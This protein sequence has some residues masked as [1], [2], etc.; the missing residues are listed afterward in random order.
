MS[1]KI[2]RFANVAFRKRTKSALLRLYKQVHTYFKSNLRIS[3]I[4]I[5]GHISI[6]VVLHNLQY[7]FFFSNYMAC[8]L[9]LYKEN[10]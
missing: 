10:A 9:F 5:C 4:C 2:E 8:S 3:N 6:L 7:P 1:L